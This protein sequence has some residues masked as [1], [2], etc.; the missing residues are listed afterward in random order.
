[1]TIQYCLL[2]L[3]FSATAVSGLS[4]V[5][6]S[7]DVIRYVTTWGEKGNGNLQFKDPEGISVN[8]AGFLY[9][10]DSGNH[11]IQKIDSQGEWIAQIGGFGWGNEQF[12]HPVSL[13]AENGLDV[14]VADY[15]NHRIERY[16]KDLH[17]L[18]SFQSSEEWPE[19][20]RFGFPKD[21]G[22]ST[23]G[24]LFCLDG[25]NS[26]ILK[27]DVLGNPQISFGD[28]NSEKGRLLNPSRLF[29]DENRIFV[30]DRE[31]NCVVVFDWY[32]S[33]LFTIGKSILSNPSDIS[34]LF[35]RFLIV[36]DP[37]QSAFF[38]FKKTGQL[39]LKVTSNQAAG[40][41][42]LEPVDAACWKD[43]IYILDKKACAIHLFQWAID[44]EIPNL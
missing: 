4:Q 29:V 38:V 24:E 9:I 43:R 32:G 13:S 40:C 28:F 16:D 3:W 25:E 21:I 42:L 30:S 1:M 15:Y 35:S 2:F 39:I 14:F 6:T 18:A 11:R 20:L 27:L 31:R 36:T 37:G 26:R 12:D 8:P 5:K 7:M 10:S 17:Y 33:F 41:S 44:K 19:Y 23:Q 22:I 34:S